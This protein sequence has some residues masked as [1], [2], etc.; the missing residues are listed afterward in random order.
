MHSTLYTKLALLIMGIQSFGCD[1]IPLN[2][3]RNVYPY[4]RTLC[5]WWAKLMW[6]TKWNALVIVEMGK[7]LKTTLAEHRKAV[8]R[9]DANA[10]ALA[11]HAWTA[12]HCIDWDSKR[13]SSGYYSRLALEAIHIRRQRKALKRGAGH[14]DLSYNS[15]LS[16]MDKEKEKEQSTGC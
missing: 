13:M 16:S 11:K 1:R 8:Q 9:G 7:T 14:L 2:V 3:L 15:L 4:Q 12:G 10:S 6:Y 5:P